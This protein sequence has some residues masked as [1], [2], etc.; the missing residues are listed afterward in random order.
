[1]YDLLVSL[2]TGMSKTTEVVSKKT[3]KKKTY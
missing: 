2:F 3:K 1:M